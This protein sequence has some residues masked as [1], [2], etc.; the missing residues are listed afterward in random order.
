MIT[1]LIFS[2][3]GAFAVWIAGRKDPAMDPRLTTVVLLLLAV[4]PVLMA[5]VPKWI[6]LPAPEADSP[7]LPWMPVLAVIWVIGFLVELGRLILGWRETLRWRQESA[8]LEVIDGVE[9]RS[10]PRLRGPVAAGVL[11]RIIYV[12][13]EWPEW[14]A[15]LRSMALSHELAHHRRRDPLRRWV[16][17]I[18]VAVNWFNPL[19]RWMVG[20]LLI[21]CEFSC[22]AEVIRR[23]AEA[24]HYAKA[25]C[26]LAEEMPVKSP[27]LAMAGNSGLETRVRRIIGRQQAESDA[28]GG[29]LVLFAIAAAALLAVV[30]TETVAGYTRS[31][32][33]LRQSAQPFPGSP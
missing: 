28:T 30:G 3:L 2:L 11:R 12:P 9:I 10:L 27:A 25:L 5:V 22:D 6:V 20:R 23:G 21:Q 32:I 29:W 7:Q 26:D 31:E 17:G 14:D 18:A 15:A 8:L 1:L 13:G 19:V 24:R 4:L 33:R 16:A